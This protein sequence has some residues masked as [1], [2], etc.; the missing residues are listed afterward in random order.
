M[1]QSGQ[2]L[3]GRGFALHRHCFLPPFAGMS[4]HF[5]HFV[6][7]SGFQKAQ[8]RMSSYNLIGVFFEW[9]IWEQAI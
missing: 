8:A 5:S 4:V 7:S 9:R 1:R 3:L 6:K 2:Q